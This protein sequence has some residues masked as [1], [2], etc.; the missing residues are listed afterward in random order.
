MTDTATL[1]ISDVDD[2]LGLEARLV[3]TARELRDEIRDAS[4]EGQRVTHIPEALHRR[5]EEA[6]FYRMYIPRAHGGLEVSPTTFFKVVQEIAR[7]DMGIGWSFCLSANHA[8]MLA[9]WFPAEIHEEVYN[10]GDFRA[11]SMYAPTVKATPVDGG[12]EID[13]V[14]NYC[15]GIPYS[16]YFLGQCI[17]PGRNEDGS[18]RLGLYLAPAGTYEILDDWGDMLGLNS[19]GS[20]SIRFEKSFLPGRFMVEDANLMDFAF[21]GDSP[22]SAAY[23]NAMYSARH[24]SSF[25]LALGVLCI[26]GA[27]GA[28]DEYASQMSRKITIPPFCLRSEDPDF[29][30]Y[31]GGA[32]VK[33]ATSEAAVYHALERWEEAARDNV[34][35]VA[36]F[37]PALDNLLGGIGREVMLQ[38]W[39]VVEQDLYRTIGASASKKG[40]RFELIFR[41]MAQA[42][43]HRNPQLRDAAF[44]MVALDALAEA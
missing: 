7:A 27:Y 44:K 12:Y 17:L 43:G 32:I 41:D 34:A 16:T 39:E 36:P 5:F 10:G 8:L 33:L 29:Q 1:R 30:R 23:G 28:L 20:N 24:G 21:D 14:V 13:G 19:S 15:S 18:P 37:S 9:N 11:A 26:G 35:G 3:Q 40:Q 38:A 6:G 25:A 42:A 2:A 22:G 31:Y 4:A